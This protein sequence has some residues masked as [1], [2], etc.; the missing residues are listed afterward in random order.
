M[1]SGTRQSGFLKAALLWSQVAELK[2][3]F[4]A[5]AQQDYLINM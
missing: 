5:I 4:H 2:L 3:V 1:Q